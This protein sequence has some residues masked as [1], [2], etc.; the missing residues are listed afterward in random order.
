MEKTEI[1]FIVL[2]YKN[3]ADAEA[4][5][6]NIGKKWCC[7]YQILLLNILTGCATDRDAEQLAQ[8]TGSILIPIPNLGY[9]GGNNIGIAYALTHYEFS[10]LVLCNPDILF[11]EVH[12]ASLMPPEFPAVYG[13]EIRTLRNKAQ[14]PA[15]VRENRM[16]EHLLYKGYQSANI[17]FS[18][19]AHAWFRLCRELF[20]LHRSKR[21][22]P[23][24]ALHGSCLIFSRAVFKEQSLFDENMFL[25]SE[26]MYLAY[27]MKM[28]KVSMMYCP[29]I[30]VLHKQDGSLCL[31]GIPI[32]EEERKSMCYYYEH[33]RM[34]A[35]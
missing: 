16:C 3:I 2:L 24:Y 19:A 11:Q 27:Q 23:V 4:L 33:Y 34:S 30:Q 26:E 7:S 35:K 25:F 10:Y 22:R 14:N 5:I 13:P 1:I 17:F 31:S 12:P 15:W 29:A 28:K 6:A 18:T 8:R 9:G 32:S 20:L 21:N